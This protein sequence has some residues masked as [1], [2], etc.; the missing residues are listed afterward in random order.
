MLYP[1]V[2]NMSVFLCTRS[3]ERTKLVQSISNI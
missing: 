2:I 1:K 3:D